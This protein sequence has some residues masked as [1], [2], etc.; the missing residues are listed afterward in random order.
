MAALA[1]ILFFD[2]ELH[3]GSGRILDIGALW[4]G[5]VFR[6]ASVE[7]FEQFAGGAR[8]LCGHNIVDHDLPALKKYLNGSSL[9]AKPAIDTLYWS[10]LLFPRKPYHR[11]VKDYQLQGDALNNPLADAKLTRDLL[12]DL[13]DAYQKLPQERKAI[14]YSL[15]AEK[16]DFQ[17]FFALIDEGERPPILPQG[18]LAALVKSR[19]AALLCGRADL[20]ELIG[21]YPVELAYA[22]ALITTED[23]ESLPP[24][25]LLH[26]FPVVM[27]VINRLRISCDGR[28]NCPYCHHLQ[29]KAGL[30]KWFGFPGFRRFEGDGEQALQEQV[31]EAALAGR[32]LIAVFP[33]AAANP[34]PFSCRP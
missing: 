3:T 25:W 20:E 18:Q 32:S 15:L 13:L 1:D 7:V 19:Y 26:R 17:G 8:L 34:S 2:L 33:P 31:V 4:R 24:P 21:Q 16:P 12:I 10:A 6:K 29:P 30:Q 23:P 5:D 14:Y 27:Q 22:I 11:L 9:P 28:G